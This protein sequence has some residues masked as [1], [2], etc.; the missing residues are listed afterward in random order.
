MLKKKL[1]NTPA[2]SAKKRSALTKTLPQDAKQTH[3]HD[4][5]FK[6]I[7]SD[8]A[9]A[10]DIFKLIFSKEEFAACK[11]KHL[12]TEKD[13]LNEKRADLIFSVPLKA[14]PKTQIKVFILVE[15]KSYKDPEVF[16]QFLYYQTMLY[17]KNLKAGRIFLIMPVLFFHGNTPWTGSK[18]FQEDLFKGFFSKIPAGFRKNMINYEIRLLDAS[19]LKGVFKDKSFKSRGALYLLKKIWGLKLTHNEMKDVLARFAEFE[20]KGKV[21]VSVADYLNSFFKMSKKFKRIWQKAEKELIEEGILNRGGYMDAIKHIE[22][23]GHIKGLRKGIQKG[24][25]EGQQKVILNML[26]N[27]LDIKFVSKVT[28]LSL[29]EIKKLKNGS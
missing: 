25:Q 21:I 1:K 8:P 10:V 14:D 11:W 6:N 13:S 27:K 4:I 12:K 24:R 22:E 15:H 18:V 3:H 7:Y 16:S 28:G 17:E 20:G 2:V 29:K 26:K 5:F 19:R 9:F 23:R